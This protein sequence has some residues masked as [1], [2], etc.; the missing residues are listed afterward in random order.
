MLPTITIDGYFF[1][2]FF[3]CLSNSIQTKSVKL[4]FYCNVMIRKKVSALRKKRLYVTEFCE[5]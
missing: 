1:L 5:V 2:F 3:N 4:L